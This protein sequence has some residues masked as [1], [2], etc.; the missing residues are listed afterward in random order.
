MVLPL[1]GLAL[2]RRIAFTSLQ[3]W[4]AVRPAIFALTLRLRRRAK[5]WAP[6]FRTRLPVQS[7]IPMRTMQRH[8]PLVLRLPLH[9][10]RAFHFKLVPP[11]PELLAFNG[12]RF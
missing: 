12:I 3:H 1:S 8:F 10:L 4:T 2:Q 9:S 7:T 6:Q 11:L 5:R